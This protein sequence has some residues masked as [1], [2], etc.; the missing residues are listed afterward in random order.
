VSRL[1]V[2]LA[3]GGLAF[4]LAAELV[5]YRSGELSHAG[6]DLAV[7]WALIGC[8]LVAWER[9]RALRFGPLLA[10]AG[11]AWFLGTFATA[12]LYLH[13]GP[14]V[15]ALL[16]YPS[17]RLSRPLARAVAIA[18]YVDGAI[19]P[20][21]RSPVATLVL[22]SGLAA[23]AVDGSWAAVGPNRRAR[24]GATAGGVAIAAVLGLGATGRLAGWH[25]DSATLWAYEVVLVLVAAGLTADLLAGR[26]SQG[27]VTGLVVDLGGLWEPVTLRDKLARALGDR[28]LELGYWLD[29]ERGYV[30]DAGR[31]FALPAPGAHRAVS[32][33][34]SDGRRVAVLVHDQALLDEPALVEAV[35]AAARIA[36]ANVRLQAQV[37]VRAEELAASRRRILEAAD[38]QRRQL[39]RELH[40]G[41]Q[42][43]LAAVSR[44]VTSLARE[45]GAGR[46]R[47]LV[48]D[49]QH[50][51]AAAR[52]E[53]HEL[54]NGIHP[55]ALT[56]G[57][58][59]AALPEL[60]A[61]APIPV[62]LDV[63]AARFPIAV[64]AAAYFVCAEALTNIAKYAGASRASV[65][66]REGG[67]RLVVVIVDDGVGGAD[68]ARGSGLRGLADR[69]ES[70]GGRL[71][72]QSPAG[73]GTR[74]AAE[75]PA[76]RRPTA[77]RP[78]AARASGGSSPARSSP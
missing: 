36:V 44:H 57:G 33:I 73:S 56:S 12:A 65:D 2:A 30:D 67:G 19:E 45:V 43:R 52:S 60:A 8:G 70:L 32:P 7:G 49:V 72:V 78:R 77:R 53:L 75:I 31:P 54:A 17:G 51:L 69:V 68:A 42:Q 20:L 38:A 50:Q 48:D 34:E 64:E 26:W 55:A 10:A 66:I 61:R 74:L 58:L 1:R 11:S 16:S 9:R 6:A 76:D 28:S 27:A 35:A 40:D 14:L 15:H 71:A 47:E 29:D 3:V 63:P 59:A 25:I 62:A 5:A 21:G 37:R 13:R 39:E 24:A 41:A 4:G 23:A 18:A 46:A 22:C